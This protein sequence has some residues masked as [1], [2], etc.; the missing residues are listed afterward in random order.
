MKRRLS[1]NPDLLAIGGILVLVYFTFTMFFGYFQNIQQTMFW[2]SDARSYRAVGEWLLSLGHRDPAQWCQDVKPVGCTNWISGLGSSDATLV[3]PFF[4]S[5]LV[6]LA[7]KAGGIY[8]IWIMQF[9][10]WVASGVLLYA[11]L[12][13]VAKSR[14]IVLCGMC[15]FVGNLTLIVLTFHALTEVLTT[16]LLSVLVVL[17]VN[18]QNLSRNKFWLLTIFIV[19]L[20]T[21]T[22]PVYQIL[23]FIILIYRI[24]SLIQQKRK[25][26][27][28]SAIYLF[29]ALSPVL[30]QIGVMKARH[31]T[32][33][34]S[35]IG[36]FTVKYYYISRVYGELKGLSVREA[37]VYVR[38]LQHR[39]IFSFLVRNYKTSIRVYLRNI[40]ENVLTKSNF[41]NPKEHPTLFRYMKLLNKV[42]Y[43]LHL[44]MLPLVFVLLIILATQY[45]QQSFVRERVEKILYFLIP[46]LLVFLTSG[47]TFWQGDR[48]VLPSLPLWIVLYALTLSTYWEL[49]KSPNRVTQRQGSSLD[50]RQ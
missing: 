36:T 31:N 34:I 17:I 19:S 39:E 16:F 46:L 12:K 10:L 49:W 23:L 29:L 7:Y 45:R 28:R 48:V 9:G 13:K 21:V 3:R 18:N 1:I 50:Y 20:L 24:G 47:I 26:Q 25:P 11:S 5:L 32:F 41:I 27:L 2:A 30:I 8:G 4:Y 6:A 22:K 38:A 44:F 33:S 40:K 14:F 37:R 15:L 42:Y 35:K 43:K